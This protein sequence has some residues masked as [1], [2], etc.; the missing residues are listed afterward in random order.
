MG[1]CELHRDGVE[2]WREG[3]VRPGC[4]QRQGGGGPGGPHDQVPHGESS[5]A[6]LQTPCRVELTVSQRDPQAWPLYSI[7]KQGVKRKCSLDIQYLPGLICGAE[8][9]HYTAV[10]CQ[11][12]RTGGTLVP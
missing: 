12:L 1:Q 8:I 7:V 10:R 4:Q 9:A 6:E 3:A 11:S 2:S 5:A